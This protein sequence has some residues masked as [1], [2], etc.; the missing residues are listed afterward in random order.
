MYESQ[1]NRSLEEGGLQLA[2]QVAAE[3]FDLATPLQVTILGSGDCNV[4]YLAVTPE[5]KIVIKLSKPDREEKALEG[6]TKERWCIA[7]ARELG[8]LTPEVIKVGKKNGRTYMI[9]SFVEG[10]SGADASGLSSLSEE[11]EQRVWRTLGEYARA[12]HLMPVVGYGDTM[13]EEGVFA[14]SWEAHLQYNID[15]LND[16]DE[17]IKRNVLTKMLSGRVRSAFESLKTKGF[18]FGLSHSDLALRNTIVSSDGKVSL[19]DWDTAKAEIVPHY[20]FN[21][22]LRDSQPSREAFNAFL[23]GYGMTQEKFKEIEQDLLVLDLL[24]SIDTLR[25]AIDRSPEVI[26]QHV[27]TVQ[28]SL[29][30]LG[31]AEA[32]EAA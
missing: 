29:N 18:R 8:V 12:I 4:N 32:G 1:Q 21:E 9:Q 28:Q 5:K 27:E 6:Y 23:E 26:P 3:Y 25:W 7:K 30:R 20:D 13:S 22:I 14:G 11:E 19:L 10:L 2:S 24:R 17:L 16:D 15:S 31:W